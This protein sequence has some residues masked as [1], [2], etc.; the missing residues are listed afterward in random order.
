MI[1]ISI[2]IITIISTII[3]VIVSLTY[4]QQNYRNKYQ[5]VSYSFKG[6]LLA[7]Q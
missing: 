4:S 5:I 3:T 2:Q 7:E 6:Y 1:I